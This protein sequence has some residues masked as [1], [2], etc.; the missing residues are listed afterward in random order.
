MPDITDAYCSIEDIEDITLPSRPYSDDSR[1]KK[2]AVEKHARHVRRTMDQV[3][4][5]KG[6]VLPIVETETLETVRYLNALG[7]A[8]I[9]ENILHQS[10]EPNQSNFGLHLDQRF[11]EG[12]QA[13]VDEAKLKAEATNAE[14]KAIPQDDLSSKMCDLW[15]LEKV[16]TKL[17]TALFDLDTEW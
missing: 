8:A 7:T 17:R 10:S 2:A 12:M 6:I 15:D 13:L 16:D 3:F 5:G 11:K 4:R 1:P 14:R 9:V